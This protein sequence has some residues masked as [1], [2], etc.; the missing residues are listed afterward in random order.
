M[1][2]EQ[3]TYTLRPGAMQQFPKLYAAEGWDVHTRHLGRPL[4]YYTSEIG[5]LNQAVSL[6]GYQDWAD[7]E[8]RR[9][10]LYTPMPNGWL[11][12]PRSLR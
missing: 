11:S 5:T 3:R 7:R 12:W 4:G 6:W 8:A 9:A 2:I 10:R 1:I